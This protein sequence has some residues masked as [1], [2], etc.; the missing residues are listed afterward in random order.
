[1]N[2]R[3]K[4]DLEQE[5]LRTRAVIR[6]LETKVI[7]VTAELDKAKEQLGSAFLDLKVYRTYVAILEGG[8]P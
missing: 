8:K 6:E 2:E 4:E 3:T 1:M 5:V 7:T